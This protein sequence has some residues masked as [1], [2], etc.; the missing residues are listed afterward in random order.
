MEEGGGVHLKD[1]IQTTSISAFSNEQ[2]PYAGT[3]TRPFKTQPP[4]RCE[5]SSPVLLG[6]GGSVVAACSCST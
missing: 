4:K 1:P 5:E 6:G 2:K 3:Q